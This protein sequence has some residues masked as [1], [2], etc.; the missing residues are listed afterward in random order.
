[1]KHPLLGRAPW[2]LATLPLLAATARAET[3]ATL[4]LWEIGMFGLGVS[5]QAYPGSDTQVGR[6][7]ALPYLI[8]RGEFFR[9]DR[10]TAGLRALKT[11]R[12]ELDIGVAGSFASRADEVWARRGMQDLGT[13]IEFGP[14][15]RWNL[16]QGPGGGRWRLDLPLRGVFDLS[17]SAAH[18][19]LTFEPELKF[20]RRAQ[21]GWSYSTSVSAIIAD[22]K[23]ASTFYTVDPAFALA[24]RPAYAAQAGL[25]AWRLSASVSRELSPQWRI[26]GFARVDSVNGATNERSPLVRRATGASVGIGAAYSLYRSEQTAAD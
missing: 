16:G 25:M 15:L 13:L 5:Q 2:L 4:P 14:R 3:P 11:E 20:Q 21:G 18:R 12:Y 22:R 26:V 10:E 9:A 8:Y 17:D 7:L 24:D 6:G 19:G 23:L 1:M